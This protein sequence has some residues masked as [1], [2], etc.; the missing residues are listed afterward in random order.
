MLKCKT[1]KI[2]Y[3]IL[4]V[5]SFGFYVHPM[6]G[7]ENPA[8]PRSPEEIQKEDDENNPGNQYERKA[9][10]EVDPERAPHSEEDRKNWAQKQ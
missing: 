2:L 3:L 1:I 8:H 9:L 7:F 10:D 5:V 4:A 6:L